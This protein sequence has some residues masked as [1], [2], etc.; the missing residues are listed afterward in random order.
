VLRQ[1]QTK[2][3][4]QHLD[5]VPEDVRARILLAGNLAYLGSA[6]EAISEL[7]TAV[8]LR[9][10]DANVLYNAAC[11]YALLGRKQEAM[12]LLTRSKEAGFLNLDW[13]TKDPDLTCLRDEPEFKALISSQ[14]AAEAGK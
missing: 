5:A 12:A 13:A 2:M 10:K 8:A 1:Q 3:I 11:T 14:K 7:K 6:H 9:P 4:R